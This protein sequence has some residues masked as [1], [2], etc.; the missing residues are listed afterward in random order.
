MEDLNKFSG[1]RHVNR[2][3]RSNVPYPNIIAFRVS[4]SRGPAFGYVFPSQ[5]AVVIHDSDQVVSCVPNG[6]MMKASMP[7]SIPW[8][9]KIHKKCSTA[10]RGN[11]S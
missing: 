2:P 7:S 11:N 5:L 9:L 4:A 1:R 8:Y 3:S 6:G 10:R